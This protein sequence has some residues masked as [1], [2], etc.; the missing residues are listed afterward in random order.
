MKGVGSPKCLI[1]CNTM[2]DIATVSNYLLQKLGDDAFCPSG[3]KVAE[4]CMID[5]YHSTTYGRSKKIE[6]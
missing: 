3:Q 1:F 6:L 4:S 2:N 5:I